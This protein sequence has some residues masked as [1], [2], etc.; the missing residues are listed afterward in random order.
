MTPVEIVRASMTPMEPLPTGVAP[1]L[2]PLEGIRAVIFDIYGTLIISAAGD[3]SLV[4]ESSSVLGMAEAVRMLGGAGSSEDVEVALGCYQAEI[5]RLQSEARCR[6]EEYPEV[7][8]R[9]V[10][11]SIV[12]RLNLSCATIET[13]ALAY[14]CAVNPCGE[15]PGASEMIRRLKRESFSLGIIS[16]AQFYTRAVLEATSGIDLSSNSF[17]AQLSIFS[18]RE[19]IAKPSL[20]LFEKASLNAEKLGL[21]PGEVLYIGN[22]LVKDIEPAA[23]TG[24]RTA[25]FAGDK[26][27][28]RTGALS[29]EDACRKADVVLT[30]MIQL[31]EVLG[32]RK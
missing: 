16:N 22:D 5:Q 6:G 25:L 7:E 9:E 32:L 15:M 23:A 11:K 3:I 29:T 20:R 19:G 12:S 14:E 4:N 8:I 27:S 18:Y 13:A 1:S 30:S 2:V 28:F 24:F 17:E 21:R 31:V 10:W 26:R